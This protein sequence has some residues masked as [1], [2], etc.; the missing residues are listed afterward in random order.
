MRP[1]GSNR[2][3][4]KRH[5][6][7]SQPVPGPIAEADLSQGPNA[8]S[9]VL[10]VD[11]GGSA[12]QSLL[13]N[14][15][16]E[17]DLPPQYLSD[18]FW[19]DVIRVAIAPDQNARR[20]IAFQTQNS[21]TV[22]YVETGVPEIERRVVIP[23]AV[24]PI[25]VW[26]GWLL[27]DG[28]NTDITV[29][30]LK[31]DRTQIFYRIQSELYA[32]ERLYLTLLEPATMDGFKIVGRELCL[33]GQ[34]KAAQTFWESRTDLYPI[35]SR[36]AA[37]LTHRVTRGAYT[38][39]IVEIDQL[40]EQAQASWRVFNG[41]YEIAVKEI[42]FL[43]DNVII[44]FSI[45]RGSYRDVNER[46]DT[47]AERIVIEFNIPTGIYRLVIAS[48]GDAVNENTQKEYRVSGGT[49]DER[50]VLRDPYAESLR[51]EYAIP[52]GSF[53]EV[54]L[55][56]DSLSESIQVKPYRVDRGFYDQ[57]VTQA[58]DADLDSTLSNYRVDRGIYVL[59]FKT[60][61]NLTE[62]PTGSYRVD[63]GQT[64]DSDRVTYSIETTVS[65]FRVDRGSYF[66]PLVVDLDPFN[67]NIN[68]DFRVNRGSYV[69]ITFF[70]VWDFD[71]YQEAT[72]G[73]FQSDLAGMYAFWVNYDQAAI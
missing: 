21:T 71:L 59:I 46:F 43:D 54:G 48:S 38:F 73:A 9:W 67:E 44:Q 63:R 30:Y 49:F 18:V 11:E 58:Y 51:G 1:N 24:D 20:V 62:T 60:I 61:D 23:D 3:S 70:L 64:I 34:Y 22:S 17:L 15:N 50:T 32:I 33:A 65:S 31:T 52:R 13:P 53:R 2:F 55:F 72:I 36:D 7:V 8:K 68:S 14:A 19:Q 28:G 26:D 45:P 35:F 41:K 66:V 47:I 37:A 16:P 39:Y 27:E 5:I 56:F 40:N 69:S 4:G 10:W 42:D 6:L 12:H 57:R 29:F 25:L